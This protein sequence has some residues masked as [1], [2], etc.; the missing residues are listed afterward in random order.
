VIFRAIAFLAATA[1]AAAGQDSGDLLRRIRDRMARNLARIPNY[2]CLQSVDRFERQSRRDNFMPYDRIRL[3]VALVGGNEMFSWPGAGKFE[4]RDLGSFVKGGVAAT[5]DYALHA[6]AIF[7]SSSPTFEFAGEEDL[8]GRRAVR[9][10]YDVPASRSG[11]GIRAGEREVTAPYH[12]SFWADRESLE[13]MRLDVAVDSLPR[14]FPVAGATTQIRYARTRVGDS[15]FLLPRRVELVMRASNGTERMNRTEFAR[16]HQYVGETT[17]SFDDPSAAPETISAPRPVP[18]IE[19]PRG[20]ALESKLDQPLDFKT[21]ALGD[22]VTATL[23]APAKKDGRIL[24]PRGAI[25]E[26]RVREFARVARGFVA[27]AIEMTGVRVQGT[28]SPVSLDLFRVDAG[29]LA[30]EMAVVPPSDDKPGAAIVIRTRQLT[31]LPAGLRL[32]WKTF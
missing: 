30:R 23:T 18:Q 11:Y 7:V 16:C 19:L 9:F 21:V 8:D 25:L 14:D 3:E 24:I 22:T 27:L 2:T 12:G 26:G 13:V 17:I 20:L 31:R 1:L 6:H 15:D 5:G 29:T 4:D 10:D 32:Y 28:Q